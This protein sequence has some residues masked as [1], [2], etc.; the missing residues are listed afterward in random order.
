MFYLY[1]FLVTYCKYKFILIILFSLQTFAIPGPLILSITAGALYGK[2]L[3]LLIVSLCASFGATGCYLLSDTLAKYWVFKY[4]P[5]R[6]LQFKHQI[7]KNK[8]NLFF[9]VL[10]LRITPLVPNWLLNLSTP[11]VG[12]PIK[13]FFFATVFG[14][15]PANIMHVTMGSEI[16]KLERIGFD[17][18]ILGFLLFLGFFALIPVWVKKYFGSKFKSE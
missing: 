15:I 17:F 8:D 11:I 3:G 10:F 6:V 18:K 13:H 5:N 1:S 16:A 7:D 14:L 4:F 12:V 9:Y 2:T